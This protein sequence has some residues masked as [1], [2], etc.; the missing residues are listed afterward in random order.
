MPRYAYGTL[1]GHAA[2][3]YSVSDHADDREAKDAAL[4]LMRETF[5][6]SKHRIAT[7]QEIDDDVV[8]DFLW[9]VPDDYPLDETSFPP[10]DHEEARQVAAVHSVLI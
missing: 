8:A 9:Q 7:G 10:N 1:H 3:L 6:E 4:A 5:P 2:E